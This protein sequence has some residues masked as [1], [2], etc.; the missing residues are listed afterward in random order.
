MSKELPHSN[1]PIGLQRMVDKGKPAEWETIVSKPHAV[2]LH[3]GKRAA[4]IRA[5]HVD[6]FIGSRFV[7]TRKPLEEGAPVDPNDW[8]HSG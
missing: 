2:K 4:Q 6:R 1:N 3:F 7:L 8:S 5:E